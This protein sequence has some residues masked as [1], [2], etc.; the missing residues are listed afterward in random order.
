MPQR[1]PRAYNFRFFW[2]CTGFLRQ[3]MAGE[4]VKNG[5]RLW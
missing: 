5:G 3:E 1:P 4:S 2:I